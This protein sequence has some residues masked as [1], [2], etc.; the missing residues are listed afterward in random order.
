MIPV[1]ISLSDHLGCVVF[2]VVE[3]RFSSRALMVAGRRLELPSS[4]F[5]VWEFRTRYM[6]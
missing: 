5:I 1:E 3:A 4:I 2:V 6:V